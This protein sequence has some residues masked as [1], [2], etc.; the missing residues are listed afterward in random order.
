[1]KTNIL[2]LCTIGA[3]LML[4]VG[5]HAQDY[6]AFNNIELKGD[7]IKIV[8]NGDTTIIVNNGR[9]TF[10]F[11]TTIVF[12]NDTSFFKSW[13]VDSLLRNYYFEDWRD[14]ASSPDF[15]KF[16]KDMEDLAEEFKNKNHGVFE[17]EYKNEQPGKKK[18]K[19]W[20]K[21]VKAQFSYGPLSWSRMN[22]SDDLFSSPEGDYGLKFWSGQRWMLGFYTTLF[23]DA[24]ISLHMGV[25][26]QSDVF[27]FRNNVMWDGQN[28]NRIT[29]SSISNNSKIVA[30]YVA[31]PMILGLN[32][33]KAW[34]SSLGLSLGVIG[35]L[36][37]RSS[38]T[39]FKTSYNEG[40]KHIEE[41]WGTKFK[42]FNK[43]KL[44]AHVGI[45][46]GE[47]QIYCE[48]ALTPLFK[49][50]TERE[51]YPFSFGIMLGL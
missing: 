36:N 5:T 42:N 4:S 13:V 33:G 30:R 6:F 23:P 27:K 28:S 18:L 35:G 49:E 38:H 11:D 21:T 34:D 39:G 50:N 48:Q 44:D 2:K 8:R 24:W 41:S 51:V 17:Y 26:Y 43:L 45:C 20:D 25:L 16:K 9:N 37:F 31:L 10:N 7:T 15:E 3:C 40:D 19:F 14:Y 1:M 47:I 46:W 12:G 32:I 29:A 22:S